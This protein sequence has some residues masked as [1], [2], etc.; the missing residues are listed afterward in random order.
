VG[1]VFQDYALLPHLTVF[2]N[3]RFGLHA[4][5]RAARRART[6]EVLELVGLADVAQSYPRELSGGQQQRVALARSL[7]PR[8]RLL[9]LDEPFSSLDVELRQRLSGE[10]REI[11]KE[12]ETTALLVTHD[13]TEA[14]AMADV[15]GVMR[16]GQLEQWDTP[17]NLYHAPATR[18]VAEFVG[19]GVFLPGRIDDD[20]KVRIE[21]GSL[22]GKLVQRL[23]PATSVDVLL[24][25]DDI[26]HDATSPLTAR[27]CARCFRGSDILYTLCLPSGS[28]LLAAMA[29][30]FNHEVG[31][32]IG[33]RL[34]TEHVVV[35]PRP[36]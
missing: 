18:F 15:V 23:P 4:L 28:H 33:V 34:C 21:M 29:S 31:E 10:L 17:Y 5:P 9:L 35:F 19:Q 36:H 1:M 24:R 6:F 20:G 3:V 25:P 22:E 27:V 12:V 30:H 26:V 14:F 11:L 13:Q 7:A 2:E 8:P 32:H 16:H